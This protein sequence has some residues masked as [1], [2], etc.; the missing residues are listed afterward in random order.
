[1]L[2]TCE[3]CVGELSWPKCV[4]KLGWVKWGMLELVCSTAL[5]AF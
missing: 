2:R 4:G 3:N 5:Q 1:M